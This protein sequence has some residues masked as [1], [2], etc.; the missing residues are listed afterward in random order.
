MSK[1]SSIML[2]REMLETMAVYTYERYES[3]CEIVDF[4][5]YQLLEIIDDYERLRMLYKP[6][7][8]SLTFTETHKEDLKS[9]C[10]SDSPR[11]LFV[12]APILEVMRLLDSYI[13]LRDQEDME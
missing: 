1:R 13:S 3:G 6:S 11:S 12:K 10:P 9:L 4:A 8:A 2:E 7:V 5:A